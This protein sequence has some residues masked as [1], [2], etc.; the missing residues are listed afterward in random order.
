M[1][2]G[3]DKKSPIAPTPTSKA[4]REF[5]HA[6]GLRLPAILVLGDLRTRLRTDD[7][8]TL[9]G[10]IERALDT[11]T[12]Q[13]GPLH[14]KHAEQTLL[15]EKPQP[16]WGD[17]GL[18]R[19]LLQ[20]FVKDRPK[21][22]LLPH[23][24]AETRE[25]LVKVGKDIQ[26]LLKENLKD[27][28]ITNQNDERYMQTRESFRSLMFQVRL[29]C[30]LDET[31]LRQA[32]FLA[33]TCTGPS[34]YKNV[35]ADIKRTQPGG[36]ST[37]VDGIYTRHPHLK[38]HREALQTIFTYLNQGRLNPPALPKVVAAFESLPQEHQKV[39][40]QEL[41][42]WFR[43]QVTFFAFYDGCIHKHEVTS[44]KELEQIERATARLTFQPFFSQSLSKHIL[45][46]VLRH[47]TSP[48]FAKT[49]AALNELNESPWYRQYNEW[50][51]RI[52]SKP[53]NLYDISEETESG[54]SVSA[55][56]PTPTSE[57]LEFDDYG[58]AHSLATQDLR[59]SLNKVWLSH[60]REI[61]RERNDG[62]LPK[63]KD[64]RE[65]PLFILLAQGDTVREKLWVGVLTGRNR[66]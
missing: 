39:I 12:S 25:A 30:A 16:L 56:G 53:S 48:G 34:D 32:V 41:N 17:K 51:E 63:E 14:Y 7:V 40:A 27:Q 6:M 61:W 19:K 29:S 42:G 38:P 50:L 2:E 55:S 22:R 46:N 59:L 31:D 49:A 60:I 10:T 9:K 8:V 24:S 58:G 64:V 3:K 33:K 37:V 13:T 20:P 36:Y 35:L 4:P 47:D 65:S 57:E 1:I 15:A 23:S 5:P 44:V 45:I 18:L 28:S 54:G 43:S 52:R 26:E 62:R 21:A 11:I 66:R